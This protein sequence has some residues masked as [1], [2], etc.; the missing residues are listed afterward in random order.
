MIHPS[1]TCIL[2]EVTTVYFSQVDIARFFIDMIWV[3]KAKI[4]KYDDLITKKCI[5]I[6][7]MGVTFFLTSIPWLENI[8]AL[9]LFS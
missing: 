7:K 2:S 5:P 1:V 3:M 4:K 8:V 9:A 6:S